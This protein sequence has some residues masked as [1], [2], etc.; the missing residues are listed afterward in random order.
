M[1]H[2]TTGTCK[3]NGVHLHYL[4]TGGDKPPLVLLHG[5]L[6]NGA[7][8][9]PLA[10]ELEGNYDVIMPDARGHGNSS[11]PN[12]GY[13]YNTL[14]S[15][16]L[17]F[18]ETLKLINPI[19]LGHSMGGMTGTVVASQ[20]SKQVKGLVL[21]D[22]TFLTPQ[23]Q[24]EVYQSDIAAQHRSILTGS[25]KE[26]LAEVQTRHKG[27]RSPELIK[28]FAQARF[29]TSIHAF[30][31]LTPPTPDYIELINTLDIPSLLIIGGTGAIVSPTVAAE[32]ACLN[33]RLE[34]IQIPEAGHGIPYDQPH[35]FSTA[36]KSFLHNL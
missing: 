35:R 2:W 16:V 12:H 11:A 25:K 22:P 5:L 1:N 6:L 10:R 31:I 9:T 13:C 17:G 26:Y 29:Q 33:K 19:L 23:Q 30:E 24:R 32:L 34:V 28:L 27:R 20:S 15:D 18:I 4:R 36:V 7:C 3:T 8:W 14:A 21:A